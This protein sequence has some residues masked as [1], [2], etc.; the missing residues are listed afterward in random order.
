MPLFL[1][2]STR[3]RQPQSPLKMQ[4]FKNGRTCTRKPPQGRQENQSL[5]KAAVSNNRPCR[6]KM[7]RQTSK[8]RS[9]H[10]KIAIPKT[11]RPEETARQKSCMQ[12]P[13][14][15]ASNTGPSTRQPPRRKEKKK[16]PRIRRSPRRNARFEAKMAIFQKEAKHQQ[17]AKIIA[18]I[19]KLER[20]SLL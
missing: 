11:R 6:A 5:R 18:N 19:S 1:T 4:P 13:R 20:A 17:R 3:A 2:M 16:N 9:A 10:T 15:P 12:R 8:G 14:K 7:P